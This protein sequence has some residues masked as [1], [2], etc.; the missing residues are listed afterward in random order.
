[1]YD[2][3]KILDKLKLKIKSVIIQQQQTQFQLGGV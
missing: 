3:K 1:M 2:P